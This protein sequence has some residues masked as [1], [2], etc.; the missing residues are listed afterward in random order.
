MIAGS[1]GN[2]CIISMSLLYFQH[3]LRESIFWSPRV[4]TPVSARGLGGVLES[5][6]VLTPR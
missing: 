4:L 5:P 2:L 3:F 1:L 6:G